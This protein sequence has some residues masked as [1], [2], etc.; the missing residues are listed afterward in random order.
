MP[1]LWPCLNRRCSVMNPIRIPKAVLLAIVLGA[2]AGS[3]FAGEPPLSKPGLHAEGRPALVSIDPDPMT[4]DEFVRQANRIPQ[5]P[6]AMLRSDTRRL[7]RETNAGFAVV[8][9]GLQADRAAGRVPVACPPARMGYDPRQLLAFLN[10]ISP[11]RRSRMTVADGLRAWMT[12]R[13]P[14][15]N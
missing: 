2:Y 10:G 9:Q 4:L 7:M 8:R 11:A 1:P 5:N 3:V 6:T 12:E 15:V 13:Y 14:C